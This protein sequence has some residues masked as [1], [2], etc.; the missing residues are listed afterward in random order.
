MSAD[1]RTIRLGQ[2]GCGTVGSGVISILQDNR[3]VIAKRTGCEIQVLKVAVGSLSDP[4]FV[5]VPEEILT[6][7]AREIISDPQVDIVVEVMGGIEPARTF[8]LEAIEGGKH[9]VCANKEL[10]STHGGE[11]LQAAEE[12]G[13]DVAYEASVGGGIPIL[14]PLKYG[15]AGNAVNQILGIVNGTTNYVL[16]RMTEEGLSFSEAISKAQSLGYAEPD[17]SDDVEGKDAA[18]KLAILA[19]MAFNSR[20]ALKDVYAEGITAITSDDIAF[21][22]DLGYVIKLLAVAKDSTDGISVRVHPTMI[23][24]GHPL[25]AVREENNAIF[26]SGD[27]VGELMFYGKGAGSFPAASA[28]VGDIIGISRNILSGGHMVGCTCFYNKPI[29]DMKDVVCRYF[30]IFDVPD[31]PG[32]LAKIAGVFGDNAVSIKSVIQ[33]GTG[34]EARIILITH[35]VREESLRA[36]VKGLESLD[37]VNRIASIIRVEDTGAEEDDEE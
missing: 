12:K 36:T 28:V 35:D 1:M 20:V 29:K 6:T 23:P 10:M 34:K 18:A 11:I 9:V 33:H 30:M 31:R 15:L 16:T 5:E 2:I 21:G 14:M 7:D 26:V 37:A 17:P 13:V 19:S 25:A 4:R 8:I 3:E 24:A 22:G 27:A 32:V